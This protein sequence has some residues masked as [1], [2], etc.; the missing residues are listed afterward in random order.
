MRRRDAWRRTITVAVALTAALGAAA[1]GPAAA[2]DDTPL[3]VVTDAPADEHTGAAPQVDVAELD[4]VAPASDGTPPAEPT[5]PAPAPAADP[6]G[7]PSAP[8]ATPP[9][10][11]G[12]ADELVLQDPAGPRVLS[13]VVEPDAEFQTVALTWPVDADVSDLAPQVRT[14]TTDGWSDWVPLETDESAPDEGT[15]DARAQRRGGTPS[16]W[17]GASDAVQIS[18][19]AVATEQLEDVRLAVVGS[20]VDE[21]AVPD[22]AGATRGMS[23][24]AAATQAPAVVSRAQWGAR[25]QVCTPDTAQRVSAV[26]VHHTAGS[27][28]YASPAEAM[29]QI[30]NDQRYHIES[31]GWCDIGYNFLVDHWGNI[32]EGRAGSLTSPVVGVHA[33]GFNTGTVGVSMLGTFGTVAPSSAMRDAVARI[34]AWRLAAYDV[35]PRGSSTW[36]TSGGENSRWPGGGVVH[37]PN[38]FGHRDVA[39]TACPGDQGYATLGAVRSAAGSY[40]D[41][42]T[43]W[44]GGPSVSPQMRLLWDRTGGPSGP[45]GVPVAGQRCGLT[46]DGC[47]QQ[48]SGASVY[49]SRAT[50]A[51]AVGGLVLARWLSSGGPAAGIGYPTSTVFGCPASGCVQTFQG[52][53]V[54]WSGATGAHLVGGLI[55][56][57]FAAV[58]GVRELGYPTSTVLGCDAVAGCRQTFQR[59][60]I[61]WS[62][63]TGAHAIGGIIGA[64]WQRAGGA[65]GPLG[66]PSSTT[67]ACDPTAGCTQRFAGGAISWTQK[68][69][70][71]AMGAEVAQEWLDQ[72]GARTVGYPTATV[73][74]C[75]AAVCEQPFGGTVAVWRPGQRAGLVGGL[76]LQRWRAVGGASTLGVPTTSVLGCDPTAGCTQWFTDGAVSWSGRTGAQAVPG[77]TAGRWREI[78]A[79]TATGHPVETR[80]SCPASGACLQRFERATL[81]SSPTTGTHSV[82]GIIESAW[83]GTGGV[84]GPLGLPTSTVLGCDP[85]AGCTQQFVG[86]SVHWSAATGARTR[87]GS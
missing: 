73:L 36:T 86:G 31:R 17:V 35:D 76:I 2:A 84:T 48:F 11:T 85:G 20:E 21:T 79:A 19:A 32:Y 46:P 5:T 58:G 15:A 42:A 3:P 75:G 63:A 51:Q 53:V 12:T 56:V 52:G 34:A 55:H 23:P 60:D 4:V 39:F 26:V 14:R 47:V 61:T 82:G 78:G 6:G 28:A 68:G 7:V 16:V 13:A 57:R 10:T 72:G 8:G 45:L 87:I 27:N 44:R 30:R 1:A 67:L 66:Y 38:V 64:T 59:S 81:A 54:A 62:G 29:A 25:A 18:V 74:G 69:G 41:A 83:R 49:W 37:L 50:G 70:A 40:W 24:L 33:G 71:V 65:S 77:A 22:V 80:T 43:D 9:P